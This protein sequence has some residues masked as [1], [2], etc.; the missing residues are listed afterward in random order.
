MEVKGA[1]VSSRYRLS[2]L[3]I[4]PSRQ[5]LLGKII[6]PYIAGCQRLARVRIS[7]SRSRSNSDATPGVIPDSRSRQAYQ[8]RQPLR[9][10]LAEQT[11]RICRGCNQRP[12][13]GHFAKRA[14]PRGQSLL[15]ES[16]ARIRSI[17]DPRIDHAMRGRRNPLAPNNIGKYT[18]SGMRSLPPHGFRVPDV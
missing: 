6:F 12:K 16:S 5:S 18:L 11:R 3:R 15:G 9:L 2:T 13:I 8:G 7:R 4:G 14:R 10:M 17:G 1:L